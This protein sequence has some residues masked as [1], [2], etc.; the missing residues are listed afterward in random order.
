MIKLKELIKEHA[1]SR[2]FGESL[3]TLE[4]S[5]EKHE[6][7]INERNPDAELYKKLGKTEN[8]CKLSG[9]GSWGTV[10]G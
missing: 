3:P 10:G 8:N 2:K 4:S 1:W 6:A 9:W 7:T 5:T